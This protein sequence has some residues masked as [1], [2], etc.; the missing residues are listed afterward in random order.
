MKGCT[1]MRAA[2]S[3][4]CT[5]LNLYYCIRICVCVYRECVN[6]SNDQECKNYFPSVKIGLVFDAVNYCCLISAESNVYV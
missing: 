2:F 4:L 6:L 3:L 5:C 1:T